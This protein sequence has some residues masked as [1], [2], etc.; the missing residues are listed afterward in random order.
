MID[1]SAAAAIL[2]GQNIYRV[3]ELY[4]ITTSDHGALSVTTWPTSLLSASPAVIGRGNFKMTMGDEIPSC[5]ITIAEGA[6]EMDGLPICQAAVVGYFDEADFVV[7]RVLDAGGTNVLVPRF[8]GKV[9][10]IEPETAAL[11]VVA[12]AASVSAEIPVPARLIQ[13]G[14]PYK[15][16]DANCSY[17]GSTTTCAKTP[18]ACAGMAGGSNLAHYGGFPFVVARVQGG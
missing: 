1:S 13:P 4:T 18:A 6:L 16:K 15:F 10:Q 7:N 12:K 11:R 14:C 9:Q 3:A 8:T 5:D 2:Y 17:S